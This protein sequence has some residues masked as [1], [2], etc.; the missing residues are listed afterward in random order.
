MLEK[1][2]CYW[3]MIHGIMAVATL[4]D[5]RYKIELLEYYFPI[6]Y[7]DEADYKIQRVRDICYEMICDYSSRRMDNEDTRDPCVGE[8]LQVDDS[9]MVFERYLSQKKG[10]G[11]IK[12]ELDHQLEDDLMPRIVDFDILALWKSNGPKYPTL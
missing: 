2:D 11:N 4:L 3:N 5:P 6:I 10:G 8:D 7:G 12:L 9:L 1:F